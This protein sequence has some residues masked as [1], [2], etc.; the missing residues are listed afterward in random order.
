[1]EWIKVLEPIAGKIAG[2]KA[3]VE[4]WRHDLHMRGKIQNRVGGVPDKTQFVINID[5]GFLGVCAHKVVR[6]VKVYFVAN[7]SFYRFNFPMQLSGGIDHKTALWGIGRAGSFRIIESGS[8]RSGS[9]LAGSIHRNRLD[10]ADHQGRAS[11]CNDKEHG[12]CHKGK[13][14]GTS[15]MLFRTCK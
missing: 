2:I 9:D 3:Q 7:I 4:T 5:D 11:R 13:D 14:R 1:M 8:R 15:C 6:Y 12:C 10:S